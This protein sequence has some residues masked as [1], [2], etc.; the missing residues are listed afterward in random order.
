ME[1]GSDGGCSVRLD[2]KGVIDRDGMEDEGEGTEA[3][4]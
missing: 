4:R 3:W 2:V 1:K